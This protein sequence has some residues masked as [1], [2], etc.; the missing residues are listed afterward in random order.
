M[1]ILALLFLGGCV[2]SPSLD[3]L[4]MQRT[5][6]VMSGAECGDLDKQITRKEDIQVMRENAAAPK[7]P[8]NHFAYCDGRWNIDCGRK[9]AKRPVDWI[10]LSKGQLGNLF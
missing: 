1:K 7:C 2:T 8:P 4:Y 9:Y 3:D 10:C 5:A 6:C